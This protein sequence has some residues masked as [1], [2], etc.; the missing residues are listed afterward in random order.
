MDAAELVRHLEKRQM[1]LMIWAPSPFPGMWSCE[2]SEVF[3]LIEEPVKWWAKA[4]RLSLQDYLE[5]RHWLVEEKGQCR[6]KTK[7]GRRCRMSG[8]DYAEVQGRPHIFR[9]GISDY[10]ELHSGG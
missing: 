9:P 1:K 7:R 5:L 6:G 8:Q 4:F 10:C 3:E 2:P